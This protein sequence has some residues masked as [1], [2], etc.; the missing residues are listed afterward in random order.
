MIA[1]GKAPY[2]FSIQSVPSILSMP[3]IKITC[4]LKFFKTP[5]VN[6]KDHKTMIYMIKG[7]TLNYCLLRH[8]R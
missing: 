7:E 8:I 3:K 6:I 1:K 4:L 2:L 5:L